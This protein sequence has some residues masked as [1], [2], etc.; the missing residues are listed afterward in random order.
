MTIEPG[1]IL[2]GRYEL[3]RQLG[4]GGMARV[5]LAYD[6]VLDRE[7]AVK[8]LAERYAADPAFV[9]RF[10]REASAAA[11]LNHPNIVAVYD[12]GEAE[13]TYYIVM[14]YLG[15]PDLKRVIREQGPLPPSQAVDY[16]LQILSA[17]AAAHRR[18]IIHRDLKPQ[19]VMVGDDGRLRVADFGIARADA[20]A[21]MTEAG[22]VIGTAQYLSPE[23][24]RGEEVTPASDTYAVGIVL[25]EMLTGRVPFDGDRP[26]AVAMKQINEPPIPPQVFEPDVPDDLNAVV[27]KALEK[28]PS[29]RYASAEE[30]TQALLDVRR[31]MPG[32]EQSTLILTGAAPATAE[33]RVMG[34]GPVT[35]QT[36]V[37]APPPDPQRR[38]SRKPLLIGLLVVLLAAAG[39]AVALALTR[40]GGSGSDTVTVPDVSGL[41]AADAVAQLR[42]AGLRPVQ[43]T[44]ASDR[45]E[46]GL[47]IGTRP[48]ANTEVAKDAT[49]LVNVSSGPATATVPDVTGQSLEDAQVELERAGF[50]VGDTTRRF[51]DSVPEGQVISQDPAGGDQGSRGDAVDL[52]V[53]KGPEPVT[54]P[55]VTGQ[56]QD[57]AQATLEGRGLSVGDVTQQED[58][59][60]S[61]GTV[62]SQSPDAG[63]Q[64]DKGSSVDL[65]VAGPP[66]GVD[67]PDVTGL[68]ASSARSKL[69]S[70]G[71]TVTS[72]GVES[73]EPEGTV[74]DQNPSGG[75]TAGSG[76][77]VTIIV[78]VGPGTTTQEPTT[79]E[80][81]PTTTEAPPTDTGSQ[82]PAP[83]TTTQSSPPAPLPQS[84]PDTG[85]Q[86]PQP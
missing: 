63:T 2:G 61:E 44:R 73:P 3:G 15:G 22:S 66:P 28:R 52:V 43:R 42:D 18:G 72:S 53:S 10:R 11:G 41:A 55:D 83:E 69:E 50:T 13:G 32:G 84:P 33:T 80:A 79:T 26:V 31:S 68:D 74:V 16:A 34:Q 64:V 57:N 77:V 12:R 1:T 23:Q 17:A 20:D 76:S 27:L 46:A 38:R 24:A 45:V 47:V 35:G 75:E 48:P 58:P 70:L 8:V 5:Y 37:A 82:P 60:A 6:K 4:A 36:A 39:V 65:V 59:N 51:S 81:P 19:N 7:V 54:V 30:F 56:S 25:Y 9:E 71:F 86:P 29:Q 67:V 78:S 14:E 49:V 40:G 85:P 62:I 21:Q